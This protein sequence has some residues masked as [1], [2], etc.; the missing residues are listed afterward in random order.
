MKEKIKSKFTKIKEYYKEHPKRFW[1]IL[2]LLLIF[3]FIFATKKPATTVTQI[4][5][6][7]GDLKQTVLSTGQVTSLTDLKLSFPVSGLVGTLPVKVGD[8]V[9][10]GQ[11]LVALSNQNEYANLKLAQAKYKKTLEGSS[12]EEIA[13]AE[14]QLESAKKSLESTKATQ[15]TLVE[16]ARVAYL[17]ND[18]TPTLN[19]GTGDVT[20]VV[21]GAYRGQ[22][23]GEIV[24][25][26]GGDSFFF[27]GLESGNTIVNSKAPVQIGRSGLSIQFPEGSLESGDTWVISLPNKNSS[28]YIT[29]YN[30]YQNSVKTRESAISAAEA[31]LNEREASL[32]LKKA[33][34]RSSDVDAAEAEVL[35]A[36][37][38][39]EKTILRAPMDGTVVAVDTKVGERVD[40]QKEVVT[41][42]DIGSLYVESNINETNIAKVVLGQK[43]KMTLDAF[44]PDRFFDGEIIHI[45][46][47]AT[48][49]DGVAN[50]KIKVSIQNPTCTGE[51]DCGLLASLARPGMNANMTIV[52]WDHPNV[53]SIPKASL[54]DMGDGT[55][56][57]RV[58]KGGNEDEYEERVVTIGELGDGNMVEILS[59]LNEGETVALIAPK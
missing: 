7:K 21:S 58:I 24:V 9:K 26:T 46:P 53:I 41:I 11:M 45:D 48:T 31:L 14:A 15:D 29:S 6:K 33:G 37:A 10:K 43:V 8:K 54:I 2:I 34:A 55:Y 49:T 13:V 12:T 32:S 52:A 51:T 16:T 57:V 4:P 59:G 56:K 17:N 5:V 44:G 19:F 23:E 1:A 38:T 27:S 25:K 47:S 22:E 30:A 50:Y 28:T 39:Y 3:I 36:Q 20:P 18:L 35:S 40:T 42:Q